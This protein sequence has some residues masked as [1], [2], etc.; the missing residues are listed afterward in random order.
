[1]IFYCTD[2]PGG[3]SRA[4]GE[5][6]TTATVNKIEAA[7]Q[8]KQLLLAQPAVA[9]DADLF[10]GEDLLM[11][12]GKSADIVHWSDS[13]YHVRNALGADRDDPRAIESGLTTAIDKI[14]AALDERD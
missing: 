13:G 8:R 9:I 7:P 4:T 12:A 6:Y 11:P 5:K 2:Y 10:S 14:W 1:M 3:M